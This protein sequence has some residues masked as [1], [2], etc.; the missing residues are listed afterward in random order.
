MY[1]KSLVPRYWKL[2]GS[3]VSFE[4]GNDFQDGADDLFFSESVLNRGSCH[5][6]FHAGGGRGGGGG[7]GT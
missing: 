4:K 7:G 5:K 2:P 3:F 1:S 6:V